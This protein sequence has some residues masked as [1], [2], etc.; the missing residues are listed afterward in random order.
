MKNIKCF[1]ILLLQSIK[2]NTLPL[3]NYFK[4]TLYDKSIIPNEENFIINQ[5]VK[6][7]IKLP[8]E[9]I[10]EVFLLEINKLK[11]GEKCE[12]ITP[13]I[14]G[15][16]ETNPFN[17]NK[18]KLEKTN[19]LKENNK[20]FYY[21]QKIENNELLILINKIN[22]ISLNN[23]S[24]FQVCYVTELKGKKTIYHSYDIF[25]TETTKDISLENET[26]IK[27]EKQKDFKDFRYIQRFTLMKEFWF[28]LTTFSIC[29]LTFIFYFIKM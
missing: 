9:K 5:A 12:K 21:E 14:K 6:N 18:I 10:N 16:D 7:I 27:V 13:I 20:G 29:F 4:A 8:N 2:T 25:V 26:K 19:N 11:E 24:A 22:F 23:N 17:F 1:I 3:P 28:L 15:N